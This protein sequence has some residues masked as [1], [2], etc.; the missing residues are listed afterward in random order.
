MF[1]LQ[2]TDN[3]QQTTAVLEVGAGSSETSRSRFLDDFKSEL[4]FGGVDV[5]R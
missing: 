4:R 2:P 5:S 3:I 1:S